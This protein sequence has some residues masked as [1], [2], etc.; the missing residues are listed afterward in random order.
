VQENIRTI[1]TWC[2][3]HPEQSGRELSD[4]AR[5]WNCTRREAAARLVPAGAI[6]YSMDE[7]DVR[8]ILAFP[9]T[10]IGSDGLPNDTRPHPRLWGTFPRVLGHYVRDVGLFPL[11]EAVRKMTGLT[12]QRFGLAN[13]GMLREGYAADLVLFDP[14][15]IKDTATFDAPIALAEGIACVIVNGAASYAPKGGVTNRA[16]QLL[17]GRQ[18]H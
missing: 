6:Y 11:E 12:A 5:D 10:M 18:P 17:T 4:I 14:A 3:P 7:A 2:D 15:T 1:I 9:L 13:R 16:G 8:R